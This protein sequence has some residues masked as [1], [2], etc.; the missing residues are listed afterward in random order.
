MSGGPTIAILGA[1]GLIGHQ[2]AVDLLGQGF[3]VLAVAR[4]FTPAQ[5]AALTEAVLVRGGVVALAAEDLA[6][7]M[8]AHRVDVVVN[9]IGILQ[10]TRPGE[11]E[12]VHAGFVGRLLAAV[13]AMPAPALLV[14]VSVP[15]TSGEDATAFSLSKRRGE[16][17]LRASGSPVVIIRPGFVV[18]GPAYGGSALLRALAVLPVTLPERLARR[19][20]RAVAAAD[21]SGT[22]AAVCRRW[23]AGERHWAACWDVMA[24]EPTTLGDVLGTL[25][26]HLGGPRPVLRMPALLLALG[27]GLGD[28]VARLGWRP[29]VRSTALAELRRGVDGDPGPWMA[30]TGIVPAPL[31]RALAEDAPATV[32]ERWFARMY[33]LKAGVMAVLVAF[34]CASGLIALTAA[35][36]PAR[37]ILLSHGFSGPLATAVTIAT[38]LADIAIGLL[39]AVRRTAPAGLLAGIALSLGY[40]AGAAVLAPDLWLEPLGAL[41]K[42]GPAIV[43]MGVALAILPSR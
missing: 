17:L 32:Q 15:G 19:P 21:I 7:L 37:Q 18:A 2:L 5:E 24:A 30:E 39:V 43:L 36:Q 12:D 38:S 33:L 28:V 42:T 1:N 27:A 31:A 3:G 34:W 23:R 14:H 41:V 20:F 11:S 9:A 26:R 4:R 13:A 25:R 16:Q 8:A 6:G 22:V 29:P 10:D 40:M 35:Y